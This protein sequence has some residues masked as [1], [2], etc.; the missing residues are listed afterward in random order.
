MAATR[1][2]GN[3][4]VWSLV[5]AEQLSTADAVFV[6]EAAA[7]TLLVGTDGELRSLTRTEVRWLMLI[8]RA[9]PTVPV[10]MAMDLAW[11]YGLR[12]RTGQDTEDLDAAV[13]FFPR[14]DDLESQVHLE[15]W[16]QLH[17]VAHAARWP[18]RPWRPWIAEEADFKSIMHSRSLVADVEPWP[19]PLRAIGTH[20]ADSDLDTDTFPKEPYR[21]L[22][23][24]ADRLDGQAEK[25]RSGVSERLGTSRREEAVRYGTAARLVR[26]AVER[27]IQWRKGEGER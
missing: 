12:E 24:L 4:D 2:V 21:W 13:A 16:V 7:L 6:R 5:D 9:I 14:V 26:D 25:S 22:L 3:G 1:P 10:H 27:R 15:M 18:E 11:E 20:V 19:M 23:E 8:H 17:A